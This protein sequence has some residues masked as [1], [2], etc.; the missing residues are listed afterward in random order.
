MLLLKLTIL[1]VVETYLKHY[2]MCQ[3]NQKYINI[4]LHILTNKIIRILLD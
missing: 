1:R 4:M 2:F 3:K